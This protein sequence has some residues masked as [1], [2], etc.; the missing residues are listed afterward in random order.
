MI[1]AGTPAPE[2]EL[3]A[4]DGSTVK[5]SDLRGKPGRPLLLSQGRL[6]VSR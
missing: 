4:D 6:T 2:F 1:E 5:L 3:P